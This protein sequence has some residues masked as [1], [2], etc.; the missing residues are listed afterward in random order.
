MYLVSH[1][2]INN[3]MLVESVKSIP[4]FA[5]RSSERFPTVAPDMH[6]SPA[7]KIGAVV[8]QNMVRGWGG[9]STESIDQPVRMGWPLKSAKVIET[10]QAENGLQSQV[11]EDLPFDRQ[12]VYTPQQLEAILDKARTEKLK[13]HVDKLAWVIQAEIND[14]ILFRIRNARDLKGLQFRSVRGLPGCPDY[15]SSLRQWIQNDIRQFEYEL[16]FNRK[17]KLMGIGKDT[18]EELE[19]RRQQIVAFQ[20]ATLHILNSALE[21]IR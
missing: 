18:E 3:A 16:S 8:V 10:W 2:R 1:C 13:R 20:E 6:Y 12:Q 4:E 9:T 21:W 14:E 5:L 7:K 15:P 17:Y 19:I 11:V